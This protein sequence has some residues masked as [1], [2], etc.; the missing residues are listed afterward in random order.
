MQNYS[1]NG[2]LINGIISV[3]NIGPNGSGNLVLLQSATLSKLGPQQIQ[4]DSLN[5]NY[6]YEWVSGESSSPAQNWQFS[7]TGGWTS[8]FAAGQTDSLVITSPLLKNAK[9]T[10][11]CNY[12]I[13]GQ[14][15]TVKK[16][17]MGNQYSYYDFSNP[18][19]CSGQ[20]AVTTNGTTVIQNQ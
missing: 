5:I 4:A 11:A 6:A 20:V 19:S 8:S 2:T 17:P 16:T 15:Y 10:N 14:Q 12:Y 9:T 1:L 18:G 13:S 7:V 3:T